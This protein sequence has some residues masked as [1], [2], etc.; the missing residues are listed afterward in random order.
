M[1]FSGIDFICYFLPAF[2]LC[3][4]TIPEKYRKYVL[5]LGSFI[6]YTSGT[7]EHPLYIFLLIT[8]SLVDFYIGQAIQTRKNEKKQF[9]II[10][11]SYNLFWLLLFK[12]MPGISS[13]P[14]GISFYTFKG[15]SYMVDVYTGKIQAEKRVL[16]FVLY[17]CFFP[18]LTAGP[19]ITYP[20]FEAGKRDTSFDLERF[21]SGFYTFIT[22]LGLKVLL[23]NNLASMWRNIQ[24]IGFDSV[25]TPLAWLGAI[26]LS[27]QI[28]FDFY[29]YS[30]MAAGIGKILGYAIPKNFKHPYMSRT[31]TEFWRR[32][33]ITLGAFFRNYVY[34]PLGGNR[35]GTT[36]TIRNLFVVWVL[37]GI[38]H[39]STI[40]FLLWGVFLFVVIVLEKYLYGNFLSKNAPA[41][42]LYMI[43][44]IPLSW[45][46]FQ[47]G[48]FGELAVYFSR[49]FPFFGGEVFPTLK[50][51]YIKYL[52][53][54][55]VYILLGL[56]FSTYLPYNL[57]RKIN[58]KFVGWV[59]M[60]I[61]FA[62]S[63]YCIFKGLDDPFLYFTF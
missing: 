55:G 63:M 52:S 5:V 31:M 43:L 50:T 1:V 15:I 26:A 12:Y 13:L 38:W 16:N 3:Y 61:V 22:G 51:D 39:G 17:M 32:W 48:N 46:I 7:L 8:T 33:H 2:L 11:I 21:K 44:L 28:Y 62:L 29:G 53:D 6:F 42:H 37:T 54:Y 34:I 59:F 25:S 41:G 27:L 20:Q 18:A 9:L 19:I 49:L 30:L 4:F 23:A 10:G 24:S 35:G 40:T 47:I 57:L 36:K 60:A 56:L 58:G 14:V 45:L